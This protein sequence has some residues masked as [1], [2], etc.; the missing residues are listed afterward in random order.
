MLR[1]ISGIA[2]GH[3]AGHER[4]WSKNPLFLLQVWCPF[5]Y[6]RCPK[7]PGNPISRMEADW[8]EGQ[9]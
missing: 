3:A 1:E 2:Q 9:P 6:M 4:G 5:L 8:L 7:E